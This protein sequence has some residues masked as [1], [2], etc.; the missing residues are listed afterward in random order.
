MRRGGSAPEADLFGVA[1]GLHVFSVAPRRVE[2]LRQGQKIQFL[3]Q[4]RRDGAF[5]I[6]ENECGVESLGDLGI[7]QPRDALGLPPAL[8]AEEVA[9]V[10]EYDRACPLRADN[11]ESQLLVESGDGHL[12][13]GKR[14]VAHP[15]HRET[16]A[17]L[18]DGTGPALKGHGVVDEAGPRLGGFL[19]DP[20]GVLAQPALGD[21]H[22]PGGVRTRAVGQVGTFQHGVET[23]GFKLDDF[24]ESV[25]VEIPFHRL[26]SSKPSVNP[27]SM[28]ST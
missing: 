16:R 14:V 20:R 17:V 15:E 8:A 6:P 26:H 27:M 25:P 13:R 22:P 12:P 1:S 18:V 2:F 10:V 11:W 3:Q 28:A 21:Q 9:G 7:Q 24:A 4:A 19:P 5:G 23:V